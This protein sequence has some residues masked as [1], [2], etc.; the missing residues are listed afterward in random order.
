MMGGVLSGLG[1]AASS[2]T[3]SIIELY[4]TAGVITGQCTFNYRKTAQFLLH[5]LYIIL[6]I[7]ALKLVEHII[8]QSFL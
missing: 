7:C 5:Y 1:M 8:N 3:H 4:I 2:F 6:I